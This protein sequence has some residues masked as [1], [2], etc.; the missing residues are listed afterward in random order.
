[1]LYAVKTLG[2]L[3]IGV[4]ILFVLRDLRTYYNLLYFKRQGIKVLF[5][6][7]VGVMKLFIMPK[8]APD[9]MKK[10]REFF[11]ANK[12]EPLIMINTIKT[13]KSTG[14]LLDDQLIR[15]FLSKETDCSIKV[16]VLANVNMGFFFDNGEKMHKARA[17]YANF[18]HY[19]NLK[20]MTSSISKIVEKNMVDF[21]KNHL[22]TEEWRK[23]D[24]KGLLNTLFSE[25]VNCLLFGEEERHQLDGEDLPFVI[26]S[27]INDIFK[28]NILPINTFALEYPH[29]LGL[30]PES[31]ACQAKYNKIEE[32]CG[33]LYENRLKT[34]P[35]ETPNLLDLMVS[36]NKELKEEGK[37]ILGKSEIVGDF[38]VLQ[39]AGAD[40]SIETSTT[41]IMILSKLKEEK[42]EF[43]K[44]SD[45]IFEK[46]EKGAFLVYDDLNS[47]E[48]LEDYIFEILRMGAPFQITSP[49]E[50]I[51]PTKIG[52]YHFR[53]GDR[54]MIPNGF[55]HQISLHWDNPLKFDPNRTK[56]EN[57]SKIGK[58]A[59]MPFGMGKRICVGRSLGEILVK[60]VLLTFFNHFDIQQDKD[61]VERKSF[62]ISYGYDDPSILAKI[63]K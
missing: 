6:P 8:E 37:E 14:F 28:I 48:R 1:M 30:L 2:L 41:A 43:Q 7:I 61:H 11:E 57:F 49:R 23:L 55:I 19:E 44:I 12:N 46:K 22:S 13:A 35:K 56:K 54:I 60:T 5:I 24:L 33:Q 18:F 15:E 17:A 32:M 9:T 27:Y 63:R 25:L 29:I 40:T 58:S 45:Q 62:S 34:G 39:F 26:K 59:F 31:R 52:K 4:V 53:E 3:L 16:K 50:F 21:G 36:R 47:S 42:E 20:K 51:K 10:A 38:I